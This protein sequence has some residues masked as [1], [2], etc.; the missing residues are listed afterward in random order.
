[1]VAYI[2]RPSTNALV[3]GLWQSTADP[4]GNAT[5][6]AESAVVGSNWKWERDSGV[7]GIGYGSS[8]GWGMHVQTYNWTSVAIQSGDV[9]VVEYWAQV[10][11]GGFFS[12]VPNTVNVDMFIGGATVQTGN[13]AGSE[14]TP[15][16]ATTIP[17]PSETS[18]TLPTSVPSLVAGPAIPSLTQVNPR[19]GKGLGL[20]FDNPVGITGPTL[21]SPVDGIGL[22]PGGVTQSDTTHIDIDIDIPP[23]HPLGTAEDIT[24]EPP[25]GGGATVL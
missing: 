16:H 7:Y 15:I 22:P 18:A 12:I 1:M 2:W 11:G 3:G 24:V 23:T 5:G 13:G 4:Q 17:F 21:G 25:T 19:A 8:N 9:M 20:V 14:V 10:M 6:L